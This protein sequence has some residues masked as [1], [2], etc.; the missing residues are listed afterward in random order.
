MNAF[1]VYKLQFNEVQDFLISL[2]VSLNLVIFTS[3]LCFFRLYIKMRIRFY[4]KII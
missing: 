4:I 2:F 3:L 1:I